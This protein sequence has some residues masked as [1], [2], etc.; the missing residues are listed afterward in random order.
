MV[1]ISSHLRAKRDEFRLFRCGVP[2]QWVLIRDVENSR[3]PACC[4]SVVSLTAG[5]GCRARAGTG[6]PDA[7]SSGR[8]QA[9]ERAGYAWR[10]LQGHARDIAQT[11]QRALAAVAGRNNN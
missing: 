1:C 11:P 6:A 2:N 4:S 8:A 9:N 7:T 10:V 5:G 3:W